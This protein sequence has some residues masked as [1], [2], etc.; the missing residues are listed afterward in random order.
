MSS[1]VADFETTTN[2]NDCRVWAYAIC[3]IGNKDNVKKALLLNFYNDVEA[4]FNPYGY[5]YHSTN[6]SVMEKDIR[7]YVEKLI[8]NFAKVGEEVP[9]H[10]KEMKTYRDFSELFKPEELES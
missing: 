1:F 4:H 3:E 9:E 5:R 10:I 6:N 2:I 8:K 7:P